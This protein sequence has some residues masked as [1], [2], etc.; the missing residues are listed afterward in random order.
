MLDRL[1]EDLKAVREGL[2]T[3]MANASIPE[4]RA[5][6]H[7]LIAISGA[8]G[9]DRLCHLSEALNIAAKRKRMAHLPQI[10]GPVR[11]D[12]NELLSLVDEIKG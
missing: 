1:D 4:I 9:A 11:A 12:L 8:V 6:T 5:Q 3:G 10:Y 2:E 7:I